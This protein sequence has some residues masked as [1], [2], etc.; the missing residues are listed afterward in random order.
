ME[1][2]IAISHYASIVA[3]IVLPAI[4]IGTAQGKINATALTMINQ[5]PQAVGAL[6]K[7][8]FLGTVLVE[9]TMI[10]S[11]I[12]SILFV[13]T[14]PLTVHAAIAHIG[15]VF[16]VAI[17]GLVIGLLSAKPT[18]AALE[19]IARE[20]LDDTKLTN[21]LLITLSLMQTPILFGFIIS[22]FIRVE[23]SFA[24]LSLALSLLAGGVALGIG[25]LGPLRGLSM[26]AEKASTCIGTNKKSYARVLSLTFISQALIEAPIIFSFLVGL[27]IIVWP[28][29][30]YLTDLSGWK[31]LAAAIAMSFSTLGAGI[32]SGRVSSRACAEITQAPDNFS[33]LSRAS[34][35]GQVFI[36]TNAIYGFII[37]LILALT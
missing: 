6:R 36:D 16:A 22:W 17:P 15:I 29:S 26:F 23:S 9:A 28:V 20:P 21:L 1:A 32:A 7:I 31:G 30:G 4:G 33:E 5:Q 24:N 19:S 2:F 3:A 12:V 14:P 13:L 25:A 10:I 34:L 8:F 18:Q 37:A 35:W 27:T 11:L